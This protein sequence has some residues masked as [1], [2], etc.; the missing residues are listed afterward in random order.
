MSADKGLMRGFPIQ[1]KLTFVHT[2]LQV[3]LA[4]RTAV[5][6]GKASKDYLPRTGRTP[7]LPAKVGPFRRGLLLSAWSASMRE[8]LA[9]TRPKS[10]YPDKG[11]CCLNP[12]THSQ[13]ARYHWWKSCSLVAPFLL[14]LC[15]GGSSTPGGTEK[16]LPGGKERLPQE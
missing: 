16:G 15:P 11:M 5:E 1:T 8:Q 3:T 4:G 2:G 9:R 10:Q 14:R 6:L 12:H 7:A 13:A